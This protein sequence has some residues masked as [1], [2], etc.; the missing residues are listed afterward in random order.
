M[1]H[2]FGLVTYRFGKDE[3]TLIAEW[4][5]DELL[6]PESEIGIGLAKR[7]EENAENYAGTYDVEYWL[8]GNVIKLILT[9]AEDGPIYKMTWAEGD[10]VTNTGFGFVSGDMLVAGYS[11]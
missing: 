3:G 9:I 11:R 5:N 7:R 10:K 1:G 2:P 6:Y 8:D 4:V